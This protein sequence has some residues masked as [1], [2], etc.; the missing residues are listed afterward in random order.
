VGRRA[1]R[2]H[3]AAKN[4]QQSIGG[5]EDNLD[6]YVNATIVIVNRVRRPFSCPKPTLGKSKKADAQPLGCSRCDACEL[7][8]MSQAVSGALQINLQLMAP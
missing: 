5:R 7:D 1:D 8:G 3:S 4:P 2:I 6:L